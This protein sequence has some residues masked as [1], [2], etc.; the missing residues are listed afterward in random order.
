MR[1]DINGSLKP[2]R[3]KFSACA[4]HELFTV[5]K[6]SALC[7][8]TSAVTSDDCWA[9]TFLNLAETLACISPNN[10]VVEGRNTESSF[11]KGYLEKKG[12]G[13]FKVELKSTAST[14][15]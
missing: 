12:K 2:V 6:T 10:V 1:S 15:F 4:E 8:P 11:K 14:V 5:M 7:W 13:L 9:K 3:I